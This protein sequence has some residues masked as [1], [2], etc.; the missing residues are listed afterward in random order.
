VPRVINPDELTDPSVYSYSHAIL[1]DGR[2][3]ISGQVGIDADGELAG[4]DVGSQAQRAYENVAAI[5]AAADAALDAVRKV[6]AYVVDPQSRYGDY[7]DVWLETFDDPYPCHTV[8]G[9]EQL[10][11]EEYLIEIEVEASVS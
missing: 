7:H 8:V 4:G 2:L 10:A 3:H 6:T 5:L 11:T 1:D 9:V